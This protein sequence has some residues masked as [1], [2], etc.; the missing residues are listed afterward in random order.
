[1]ATKT[2]GRGGTRIGQLQVKGEGTSGGENAGE[3]GRGPIFVNFGGGWK[4]GDGKKEKEREEGETR[5]KGGRRRREREGEEGEAREKR[6]GGGGGD[7]DGNGERE[8]EEGEVQPSFGTWVAFGGGWGRGE[9]TV[10]Q[11]GPDLTADCHRRG[12]TKSGAWFAWGARRP[13]R[14]GMGQ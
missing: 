11:E 6:V 9:I 2:Q 5:E 14:G 13:R 12:R 3:R 8:R 4:G 1:M 10:E 7:V